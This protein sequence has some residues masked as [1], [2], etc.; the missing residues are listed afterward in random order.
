MNNSDGWFYVVYSYCIKQ[1]GKTKSQEITSNVFIR[2][3]FDPERFSSENLSNMPRF[4][5]EPFGFAGKRKCLGYRFSL[6]ES[7]TFLAVLLRSNLHVA[8][9]P[10]QTVTA[11][12]GLVMFPSEELWITVKER[13]QK[14]R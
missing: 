3:R 13:K 1:N 14:S 12:A 6:A 5:F 8:L 4:A 11:K 7:M 9:A 10:D 2:C